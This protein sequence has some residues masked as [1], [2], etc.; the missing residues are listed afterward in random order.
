MQQGSVI[1]EHRKVG[2]DARAERC[3]TTL[4]PQSNSLAC[5]LPYSARDV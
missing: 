3:G 1:R 4:P 2:Q 5:F